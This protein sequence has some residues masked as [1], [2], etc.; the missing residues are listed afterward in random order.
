MKVARKIELLSPAKD[1]ETGIEA[2]NHGADAVYIG[3]HRYSARSAAGNS[4]EDI[5]KLVDYAHIYHAKVYVTLNTVIYDSE[6][7]DVEALIWEL[8]RAGVDALIVQ[9]MGVLEMNLPPIALHASTQAN[10]RTV[11]KVDFLEKVG[12]S[13]V[14]LARELS[15]VDIKEIADST[16]VALECFVHGALCTSYS[17]QC[18]IS[19]A[20]AGRSANR[21]ECA[22]FCRLP[23]NLRDSSGKVLASGKHLLSLRDLNLS[24][25]L[26]D[27]LDAGVSSLKIE[28]RLK[29][30]SY[31]KNITAYYR[32][33]L[34]E[35]FER[36]P[37][38]QPA[39]SGNTTTFFYPNPA[40]SFNRGFTTYFL[41][42]RNKNMASIDTPKSMGE[43]IGNVNDLNV[44]YFTIIGHKS[45]N[46]GD[47]L[48]F[49][50]ER[51]ELIGFRVN[52]V[53]GNRIY[54]ADMPRMSKGLTLYR[55][56]NHSFEK[57]LLKKSAERKIDVDLT[58]SENNF[59][60]TLTAIDEDGCQ[61]SVSYE[62]KKELSLKPQKEN[63][64]KQLSKLGNTPF[65]L[66]TLS[67]RL[68]D[69]W[70]MPSSVLNDMRRE[71][72]DS[73]L[74]VRKLQ[75]NK[76]PVKR[77][78]NRDLL[79]GQSLTYLHNVC[80]RQAKQF[81]EKQGVCSVEPGFEVKA[82]EN[83]PLMFTKYCIRYQLGLCLKNKPES[84]PLYLSTDKHK[85][86][87]SFDCDKC[88]MKIQQFT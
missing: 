36:R 80:N 31:V 8:Y 58:L 24:D 71:V 13:Q 73:L 47:G 57:E 14:V 50:N 48:C 61:A 44:N 9:D 84:E 75:T 72:V 25:H 4:L 49:I 7:E 11:E 54:P 27:L 56:Y 67:N 30:A 65:Q 19:Q 15:L 41:K 43:P 20:L 33:K 46:N 77:E 86:L 28:G 18:Y 63:V 35:I 5:K 82:Q 16:N 38:Y 17:G 62:I 2:I 21:G 87:L 64:F 1:L 68:V 83:V 74:I 53:D 6:L 88:E 37:E 32:K 70:F 78:V 45:I 52:R 39:S 69:N 22:Q 66:K 42:G 10:N 29:A 79:S 60:F 26:E 23:Y 12:F 59:G 40:N 76:L 55:N 51:K 3:A 81:Y 85:L 34:D